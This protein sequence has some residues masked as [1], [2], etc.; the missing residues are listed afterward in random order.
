MLVHSEKLNPCTCG[1]NKTPDLDSD[2]MVPCWAVKCFD[3]GKFIHDEN[4]TMSGAVRDWNKANPLKTD[5]VQ[6]NMSL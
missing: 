1:S 5:S 4:W 2:D 3:C 6:E